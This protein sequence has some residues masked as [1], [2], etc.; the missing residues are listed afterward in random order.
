MSARGPGND[1]AGRRPGGEA[2]HPAAAAVPGTV[3]PADRRA[4]AVVVGVGSFLAPFMGSAT[5]VAL[6]AIGREFGLG[7]A[8]LGWVASTYLLAAAAGLV[9]LGRF[10]D[11]RGRRRVFT[12]G[13]GLYAA[14]S[15]L[16]ALAPSAAALYAAR[17]AQ[18]FG[19]A[20][21]FAT[22][23]A[24][25]TSIWPAGGRGQVIGINTAAVY[26]GLS[27]G[28]FLGGLLTQH[29]GW[30]SLFLA[31][32]AL[33]L[34]AALFAA[35][36]L[37]GEWAPARGE[38]YDGAGAALSI[39][40]LAALMLGLGRLPDAAGAAGVA[41]GALL[42]AAFA[43]WEARC[44]QPLLDVSLFRRNRAFAWANVAALVNYSATFAVTF[45]L[46]LYLQEARGLTPR[47]AGALLVAQPVMM[48]A[49]SPLAGRLSDRV[50]AR[51]VASL[52][53]G[54]VAA[55]L[56]LL[57]TLGAAT[58]LP[59]IAGCLML[60]GFGFALFS[61]PNTNA[62]MAAVAP[63]LYGVASATLGTMRLTGQMLSM[64]LASLVLALHTGA[65]ARVAADRAAFLAGQRAAFL[66]FGLLCVGGVFASLARPRGNSTE[67]RS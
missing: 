38:R 10:A 31:N 57:A 66:L 26:L 36:R 50:A 32:A 5:N 60:L 44:R 3:S 53:M 23:L 11:L 45:L 34:G 14:S 1:G 12:A 54:V 18:G 30:R 15:L 64:G 22:G 7:T 56:L 65:H 28:P 47:E 43:A 17:L 37:R 25:L 42:L 20:M 46:S 29:G 51:V 19:G 24:I 48:A 4:A 62:V 58:P 16:C 2:E 9:P 33:G 63:R 13:M 27:L 61:S 35:A 6:P 49:F 8:G 59:A 55:G 41:A 21:M 39:A 67:V 52:G 40:G